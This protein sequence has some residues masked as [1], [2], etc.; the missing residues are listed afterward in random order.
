[1]KLDEE[2]RTVNDALGG[3]EGSSLPGVDVRLLCALPA[4]A[5]P[6]VRG[7]G[8][9]PAPAPGPGRRRIW[10][11]HWRGIDLSLISCGVGAASAEAAVSGFGDEG[12][13]RRPCA[14]LNVGIAGHRRHPVG[15]PVLAHKISRGEPETGSFYPTF[16]FTPPCSTA[17]VV[18]VAREQREYPGDAAC[19]MEAHPFFAA[20]CS[21]TTPELV[22]CLKVV[23]DNQ[24]VPAA[25]VTAAGTR[26]LIGA[27]L[28]LV[29]DIIA[30]LAALLRLPGPVTAADPE[31]MRLLEGRH[32]TETQRHQLRLLLQR[33]RAAAPGGQSGADFQG[34][35]LRTGGEVIRQLRKR[36][37][38]TLPGPGG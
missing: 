9:K 11:G 35:G 4:E 28:Q 25:T 31:Y 27:H 14:W 17:E 37:A 26:T 3:G 13:G 24:A 34:Q 32:F 12:E 1:M 22:H 5:K 16:S 36:L 6:L 21:Q 18:T 8:L 10:T 30:E 38:S 2:N 29:A 33:L 19:D 7:L 15:T 20:A 23:S